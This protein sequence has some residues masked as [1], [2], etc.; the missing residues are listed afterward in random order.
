MEFRLFG[1]DVEI[2]MGF[3]ITTVILGL[4]GSFDFDAEGMKHLALWVPVV[5]VSVLVHELG[6]ALAIRRQRIEPTITLHWMGGLT[7]WREVLPVSRGARIGISLAGPFAGFLLG[8]LVVAVSL[9]LRSAGVALPY[10]AYE[11][12]SSLIWVNFGWGIIN[13]APVLPFDGGHVIE[14]AFGPKRQRWALGISAL[15]GLGLAVF[16]LSIRSLWG[17]YLFGSAAMTSFMKMGSAASATPTPRTPPP[18][19]E[20]GPATRAALLR[21]RNALDRDET[22]EAISVAREIRAGSL[23][24]GPSPPIA[25][26]EALHIIGWAFILRGEVREAEHAVSEIRMRG[27]VDAALLGNL[28]FTAGRLSEA[29]G[30]LEKAL[31]D[32]DD[33]KEVFGPLIQILLRQ[34]EIVRACDIALAHFEALSADDV[35]RLADLAREHR[36]HGSSAKLREAL[37]TRERAGQ[38]AFEAAKAYADDGAFSK[39]KELCDKAIG[40]GFVDAARAKADPSIARAYA[41]RSPD[42]GGGAAPPSG[43]A[44][45]DPA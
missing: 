26:M 32:G 23:G 27:R 12:Q 41:P 45:G 15:A 37:F 33:R 31:A 28:A 2:K 43:E 44:S 20:L 13:L 19:N 30:V 5:L 36:A 25:V 18:S 17:A 7:S 24:E 8:G 11:V 4:G 10:W 14:Q 3:W 22:D 6:H 21:A 38:D 34:D 1:F 35:R 42:E 29:R 39:A 16:F 9:A 40:V